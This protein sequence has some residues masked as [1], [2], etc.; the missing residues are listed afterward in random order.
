MPK[1]DQFKMMP[2][3][4]TLLEVLI[5]VC[6]ISVGM[7]GVVSAMTSAMSLCEANRQDLIAMNIVQEKIAELEARQDTSH[8]FSGLGASIFYHYSYNSGSATQ[9]NSVPITLYNPMAG[10]YPPPPAPPPP[11][12]HQALD[13][14]DPFFFGRLY[15]YF[16][17]D[18]AGNLK[19]N[20][21]QTEMDAYYSQSTIFG[22]Y[23]KDENGINTLVPLPPAPNPSFMGM[24][25]DLN[26]DGST[27]GT[28]LNLTDN[29]YELLPVTIRVVWQD[30]KTGDASVQFRRFMDFHYL[31]TQLK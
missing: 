11:A 5:A 7:L 9:Y 25:R 16:P 4:M 28:G 3:G 31:L 10:L 13:N 27:G 18:S 2:R 12:P 24:P 29:G 21:S 22:T 14:K 6:V 30:E 19:E 8:N 15:I 1:K 17:V 26:G 23:M 20:P